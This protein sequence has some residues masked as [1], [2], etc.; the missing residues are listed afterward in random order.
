MAF[1]ESQGDDSLDIS[2]QALRKY[3]VVR[4]AEARAGRSIGTQ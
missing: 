2:V 3:M 1:A 4:R